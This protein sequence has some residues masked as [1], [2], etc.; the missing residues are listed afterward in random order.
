MTLIHEPSLPIAEPGFFAD[1]PHAPLVG[2]KTLREEHADISALLLLASEIAHADAVGHR[3]WASRL[4]TVAH[5]GLPDRFGA[6]AD[7]Y[8]A[9]LSLV[10]AELTGTGPAA[11]GYAV[12]S[13]EADSHARARARVAAVT[14]RPGIPYP[15]LTE[16]L[17]YTVASE[18]GWARPAVRALR[19]HLICYGLDP[20]DRYV[21]ADTDG[22]RRN[23]FGG[24]QWMYLGVL[25]ETGLYGRVDPLAPIAEL[26]QAGLGLSMREKRALRRARRKGV[27]AD[28]WQ[29][30]LVRVIDDWTARIPAGAR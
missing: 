12:G 21:L 3:R 23:E 5:R 4:R 2:D 7:R 15:V 6:N 24:P 18:T 9:E 10:R 17:A 8:L 1:G 30:R 11:V 29:A 20:T 25:V 16:W 14:R 19:Q 27:T 22:W 13:A 28:E 26:V